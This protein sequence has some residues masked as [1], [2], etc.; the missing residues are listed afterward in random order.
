MKLPR[1]A[2]ITALILAACTPLVLTAASSDEAAVREHC[3][4]FVTAWNH[5]DAKAMAATWAEDGNLINPFGRVASN[6]A[7]VEKLFVEE[8][9]AA[10]KGTT[11]TA[12][13][14]SVQFITPT[15]ALTDWTSEIT[16]MHDPKGNELPAFKHHVVA[17]L[18]KKD[19]H[20][21][22]VA[23]R[24]FGDLPPPPNP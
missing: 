11:Y 3:A 1:F 8:Q 9:G 7:E 13:S 19:G 12:K 17:I 4:S 15:V 21:T 14:I 24:A 23:V 22:N 2:L 6:R 10:M 16:G 20:W 18:Q 5:H